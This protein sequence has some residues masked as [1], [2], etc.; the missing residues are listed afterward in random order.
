M[1]EWHCLYDSLCLPRDFGHQQYNNVI[2][3]ETFGGD[4]SI[5]PLKGLEHEGVKLATGRPEIKGQSHEQK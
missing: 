4:I 5:L 1:V 3:G 2:Y